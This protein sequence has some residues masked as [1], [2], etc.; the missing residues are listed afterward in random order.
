MAGAIDLRRVGSCFKDMNGRLEEFRAW[1]GSR[2][3]G[4]AVVNCD[5]SRA[6]LLTDAEASARREDREAQIKDALWEKSRALLEARRAESAELREQLAAETAR[7]KGEV[8]SRVDAAIKAANDGVARARA[9]KEKLIAEVESLKQVLAQKE[10]EE[11]AEQDEEDERVCRENAQ[12]N[13]RQR[14][15]QDP[16]ERIKTMKE[17]IE[18]GKEQLS[19]LGTELINAKREREAAEAQVTEHKKEIEA[20]R[21]Q[22]GA[23]EGQR[24]LEELM[25]QVSKDREVSSFAESLSP[26]LQPFFQLILVSRTSSFSTSCILFCA[27]HAFSPSLILFSP[28]KGPFLRLPFTCLLPPNPTLL[29]PLPLKPCF[30][31]CA[32]QEELRNLQARAAGGKD[33]VEAKRDAMLQH[34]LSFLKDDASSIDEMA[35]ITGLH[36]C[37][38]FPPTFR[39]SSFIVLK[40]A[41]LRCVCLYMNIPWRMGSELFNHCFLAQNYST[42]PTREGQRPGAQPLS[43]SRRQLQ[44]CTR[45]LGSPSLSRDANIS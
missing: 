19:H 40:S 8:D 39:L 45:R 20:L 25:D 36:A 32:V 30:H 9:A 41:I 27:L 3:R 35:S 29:S 43:S 2:K 31:P 22:S 37:F 11:E 13:K 26:H 15:D 10:E 7:T 24:S 1:A 4:D 17:L 6:V 38:L 12:A 28:L 14:T 44:P 5:G 23:Y 34:M 18:Q 42:A 33:G 21:L 16:K